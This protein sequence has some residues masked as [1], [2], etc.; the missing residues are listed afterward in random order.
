MKPANPSN[1]HG[2]QAGSEH[3]RTLPEVATAAWAP[4]LRR[5]DGSAA[6]LRTANSL[7][8]RSANSK[9]TTPT[10]YAKYIGRVGALAVAL[11]VSGAVATTPGVAAADDSS[12]AS[13]SSTASESNPTASTSTS[14]ESSTST[15][16]AS[17]SSST[18]PT[19]TTSS[20]HSTDDESGGRSTE[21]DASASSSEA[22]TT[23][24]SG[25]IVRSSGG[26]HTSD[27]NAAATSTDDNRQVDGSQ[28]HT[29]AAP[30]LK[31]PT[32][33][34]EEVTPQAPPETRVTAPPAAP[35]RRI[36]KAANHSDAKQ[37]ASPSA[38]APAAPTEIGAAGLQVRASAAKAAARL[39]IATATAGETEDWT[40]Q[41]VAATFTTPLARA[42]RAPEPEPV[43]STFIGVV[44][45]LIGAGRAPG[46]TAPP[47][48]PMLWTVL[49]WVRRQFTEPLA[50][51]TPVA[52][53]VQTTMPV[54]DLVQTTMPVADLVQTT[55]P[56][57]D[58]VQTTTPVADL[59]QT[60]TP[61][62]DL[63]QTTTPV[64][65]LVQT[66]TPVADLVQTT[67]LVADL[68][69]TNQ[70]EPLGIAQAALIEAPTTT[71]IF[72]G[73]IPRIG[74]ANGTVMVPIVR[75]GDLTG[76][77]PFSMELPPIPQPP[78]WTILAE[79]E[80]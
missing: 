78:E 10:A 79:T 60:T 46:P 23:D 11:G 5:L 40:D 57:A 70:I 53:L 25:V 67:T 21:S 75:T 51:H 16:S 68:V 34:Q 74:E 3:S 47:E 45:D 6:T 69:Q 29:A 44:A 73:T 76:R 1:R 50:N 20:E 39:N 72:F 18:G 2:K 41:P 42:S 43:P 55:M 65:D 8:S 4:R 15:S 17:N 71:S 13:S 32:T 27:T 14:D 59:V 38:G 52:D 61:V 37:V 26:A 58:L 28:K 33:P 35:T 31:E 80:R 62:A 36:A 19:S 64:A 66:T 30:D 24:E 56:V 63:V 12:S 48:S 9:P 49:G 7:S 54:A 22:V 77:Q